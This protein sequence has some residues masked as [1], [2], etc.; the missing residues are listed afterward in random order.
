MRQ[1]PRRLD[2]NLDR[3]NPDTQNVAVFLDGDKVRECVAYDVDQ[4]WV[5]LVALDEKGKPLI[6]NDEFKLDV[7]KG[8]VLAA[9]IHPEKVCD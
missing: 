8:K 3:N 1:P 4:G 6:C 2:A 9:W 7:R 5:K